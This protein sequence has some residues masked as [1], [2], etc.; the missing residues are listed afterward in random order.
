[1]D[2]IL[3]CNNQH[4]R[5][6]LTQQGVV[7]TCCHIFCI[8]CSN[9]VFGVSKI[10]PACDTPLDN[11]DD[12]SLTL[13]NPTE[14]YKSSVLAGLSPAIISEISTRALSFWS[15]QYSQELLYQEFIVKSLSEKIDQ[16]VQ[17][18]D[19]IA[20]AADADIDS[21]KRHMNALK[22]ERETLSKKNSELVDSLHDKSRQFAK[23]QALYDKL[24]RKMLLGSMQNAADE[25][26][27]NPNSAA[28][29]GFEILNTSLASD[30]AVIGGN[31]LYREHSY[32]DCN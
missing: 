16:V 15:Y 30:R 3:R 24:K 6:L 19:R 17:D 21:L 22:N 28:A 1:M 11:P 9:K 26:V 8:K 25:I 13:L 31:S 23:L 7:T 14:E 10:C 20:R 29:G 27:N 5:C 32:F 4:C 2:F 18:R 12:I